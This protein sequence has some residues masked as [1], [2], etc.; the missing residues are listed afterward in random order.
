MNYLFT[1]IICTYNRAHIIGECLQS[2]CEQEYAPGLN[3]PVIVVNNNSKDNTQMMVNGF[4]NKLPNLKV[5]NES[6]QGLSYARNCGIAASETEWV[7]FL[8]DDAKARPNWVQVIHNTIEKNDFDCFGGPYYAWHHYGPPPEWFPLNGGTYEPEQ[9]YGLLGND[10]YIP[11]GN[12]AF[13]VECAKRAGLFPTEI[14]MCGDECSYGEET[15]L[16]NIMK[17]QH[18]RLGFVPEMKIDHCVLPYKY[19]ISWQLRSAYASGE[20][21]FQVNNHFPTFR[22][23]L[24]AIKNFIK[25]LLWAM[26]KSFLSIFFVDKKTWKQNMLASLKAF[27]ASVSILLQCFKLIKQGKRV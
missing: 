22:D 14:G 13:K 5:I 3:F 23:I 7:V 6:R 16:F 26:P 10:T 9:G 27:V 8:D 25:Q 11:G 18:A 12:C 4:S 2:L 24:G 19:K 21:C 1:I 17:Q 15:F 20:V